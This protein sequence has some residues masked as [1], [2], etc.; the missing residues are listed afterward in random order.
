M[1]ILI[2][3]LGALGDVIR[4]TSILPGLKAKY[5]GC[6]IDW[7]TKNGS[8]EFL[9]K[10]RLIN[11][12]YM[13]EDA[14]K[15][16]AKKYD[17][18]ISLDDEHE[19]CEL[20]SSLRPKMIVGGFLEERKRS[21]TND[22]SLWFDM[23]LLSKF[24][25]KRA[26]ELKTRNKKTYQ[27]IM[28]KILGLEYRKQ[29]PQ[30]ILSKKELDFGKRFAK[31]HGIRK[32]D[33]VIGINTGAGGRWEDKKLSAEK[34]SELI[35]RLNRQIKPKLLLFGGPEEAERN[36]KIKKMVKANIIDAGCN[37]SLMEFSSLVNLCDVIVTSD[38]LALHIG[39]ALKK[40]VVAF[41]CP[42]PL[43]E[44]ELYNRGV[45]IVPKIGCL[46]CY[47]PKCDIPPVYEVD[48]MV[49]AVQKMIKE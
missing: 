12:I 6:R 9:K 24:G 4:T 32:K 7:V 27:E 37:N 15:L 41:F 14:V 23:G 33:L 18:V 49:N 1:D 20:A 31:R 10:N 36:S 38:S 17:L 26:D 47:K 30:L 45:K 19:A 5:R 44:I 25:K 8:I 48:E 40:K 2:I 42:T 34:T 28:Y 3:K 22:S 13:I 46:A 39:V 29:Q 11:R 35:D 43:S 21:Y 16:R